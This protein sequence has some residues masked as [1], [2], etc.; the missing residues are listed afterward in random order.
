[1][2]KQKL[3]EIRKKF[4][5]TQQDIAKILNIPK[6]TYSNYEQGVSDPTTLILVT[7]ADYYKVS[8]DELIGRDFAIPTDSLEDE[9][10]QTFR[11]LDLA[12]KGKVIGFAVDRVK[13]Q[14]EIKDIK[15][16][17]GYKG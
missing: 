1:M 9:L 13:A 17:T 16:R 3:K 10:L 6:T 8:L 5:L 12:N 7:L 2:L 11:Q 15:I 4:N 14:T